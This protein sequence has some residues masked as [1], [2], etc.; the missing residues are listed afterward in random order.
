MMGQSMMNDP[1]MMKMMMEQMINMA[2]N[3]SFI[4]NNYDAN[5]ETKN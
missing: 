5:D 3:D 2:N 4:C 1:G